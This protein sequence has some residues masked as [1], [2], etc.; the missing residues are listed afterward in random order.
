MR[1]NRGPARDWEKYR[2]LFG[3]DRF[4]EPSGR[5]FWSR[6]KKI[7]RVLGQERILVGAQMRTFPSQSNI[8]PPKMSSGRVPWG[9]VDLLMNFRCKNARPS[10]VKTELSPHTCSKIWGFGGSRK[11]IK[12]EHQNCIKKPSKSS[13]G[14]ARGPRLH[15]FC[16]S[17]RG[18][19]FRWFSDRPKAGPKSILN[20]HLGGH[21]RPGWRPGYPP[22]WSRRPLSSWKSPSRLRSR[23][24]NLRLGLRPASGISKWYKNYIKLY[25]NDIKMT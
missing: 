10:M 20:R 11:N 9:N 8:N 6:I 1:P 24:R 21:G 4:L 2:P 13:L 7:G 22:Y 15:V 18:M 25:T 19:K 17:W 12:N 3:P 23:K 14:A 5:H 16:A